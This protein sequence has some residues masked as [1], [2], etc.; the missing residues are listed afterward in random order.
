MQTEIRDYQ[1]DA[2]TAVGLEVDA[3]PAKR[4]AVVYRGVMPEVESKR[5]RALLDQLRA[6]GWQV[7]YINLE[8]NTVSSQPDILIFDE[9]TPV[10]VEDFENVT[11]IIGV[12]GSPVRA[13]FAHERAYQVPS[14]GKGKRSRVQRENRWR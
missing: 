6:E 4:V 7:D 5:N 8:A 2:I 13:Q 9:C 10:S 1:Q 14:R 11:A 12:C 3:Y